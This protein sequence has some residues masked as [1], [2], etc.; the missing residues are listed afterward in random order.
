MN[1]LLEKKITI[2]KYLFF[3][4]KHLYQ[5]NI[6]EARLTG[7]EC[8]VILVNYTNLSNYKI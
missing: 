8:D 4:L 1:T 3:D 6:V 2:L 5:G 7:T